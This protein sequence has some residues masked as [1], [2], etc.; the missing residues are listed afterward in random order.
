M[1]ALIPLA[2]A[3]GTGASAIAIA[4]AALGAVGALT[5]NKGLAM[6]GGLIGLAGGAMSAFGGAEGLAGAEGVAGGFDKAA[7]LAVDEVAGSAA[8]T[9]ADTAA[10]VPS[11]AQTA[12]AGGD[13]AASA[14]SMPGSE[15]VNAQLAGGNTAVPD[16][17]ASE[18]AGNV[19]DITNPNNLLNG[20]PTNKGAASS[21][22]AKAAGGETAGSGQSGSLLNRASSW[23][24]DNKE[25]A[26]IGGGIIKGVG[27]QF[28]K[29]KSNDE[30]MAIYRQRN[31]TEADKQALQ[32]ELAARGVANLA[33]VPASTGMSLNQNASLYPAGQGP[34]AY[35]F[36]GVLNRATA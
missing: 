15:T 28:F 19:G 9:I 32:R 11:G 20:D 3:I 31:T 4:G 27:E 8:N 24:K 14:V 35:R 17:I 36:G 13:A 33:Y 18:V 2:V 1:A 34:S 23:L 26:N 12:L 30:L 21:P 5:G 16:G 7:G 29:S 6:I 22:F 25:L 10:A